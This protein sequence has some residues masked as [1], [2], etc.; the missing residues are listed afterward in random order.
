M[1]EEQ[2]GDKKKIVFTIL[3]GLIAVA[4]VLGAQ[5]LVATDAATPTVPYSEFLRMVRGDEIQKIDL[6]TIEIVA[7]KKDK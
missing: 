1:P 4:L 7:H 3:Y 6:R 2:K 5:W